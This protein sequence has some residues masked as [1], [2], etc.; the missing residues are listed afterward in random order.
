MD[1]IEVN[2]DLTEA[3]FVEILEAELAEIAFESFEI[4]KNTLLAYI[5][6]P[7]FDQVAVNRILDQYGKHITSH[8]LKTIAHKNWN[9]VWE[10]SYEPVYI[11]ENIL[12]KA[13]FHNQLSK[14]AYTIELTPN[15][16]FGTGHHPTTYMIMEELEVIQLEG[17]SIC[18]FGCGS[19]ILS[20]FAAMRGAHG[21]GIEIDEHAAGAARENLLINS[22]TAIDII[23]GGIESLASQKEAFHLI[24]ANINRNIIEESL[25]QFKSK[26]HSNGRLICAGFLNDDAEELTASMNK[27]D[28]ELLSQRSKDGWTM[29]STQLSL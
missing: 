18:D 3:S 24:I 28:F 23:S 22:V 29:L 12:I 16:S 5:Q 26:M 15:M 17:L 21:I 7:S 25:E 13:P 4:D 6:K 20:I 27:A 14:T 8:S 9:A 19:G 1:Y 2:I 10:S 11:G